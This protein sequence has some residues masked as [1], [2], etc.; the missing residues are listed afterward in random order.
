MSHVRI[1]IVDPYSSGALLADSLRTEHVDM[2]AIES[3]PNLPS[4]M[5]SRFDPNNFCE[6]VR[7]RGDLEKTLARISPFQPT[8]VIAGFESGVELAEWLSTKLGLPTNEARLS[9]ARRDKCLMAE[10]AAQSG[11]RIAKQFHSD[12][13][14]DLEAWTRQSLDW[15]VI[16]KPNRSVASD[17]VFQCRSID[18]VRRSAES[19]FGRPNVLGNENHRALVQEF[20]S[21]VEYAVDTVSCDGKHKLTAVWQYE[22]PQDNSRFVPYDA[23]RL[24]PY[25][26][27]RQSALKAY[28]FR[29]LDALG[30]RFGPAH[31][32]L[33]WVEDSPVLIE[34]GARMS[35]GVNAKLSSICGGI[36]QLDETISVLLNPDHF[37]Q[38]LS[39]TPHLQKFA[40]NVFLMP[41]QPGNLVRTRHQ[42]QLEN[43][44]TLHTMSIAT[45][46]GA[47]IE[48]VAG[49][50]TLVSED[51]HMI[52]RDIATIRRLQEDGF[53]D[54]EPELSA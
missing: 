49:L 40:A 43:L 54:T 11:L 52:D 20:L 42:E 28:A 25:A 8:H 29:L 41:H 21:G 30:I 4:A 45:Q 9:K 6:V 22:R 33:M 44:P 36:S 26:G 48:R 34:V 10:A 12:N 24:L 53:F 19:I 35:A 31:C 7:H 32:E 37:S 13:V 15:P 46:V 18:E 14:A 50:V 2:L 39:D 16:V 17:H 47:H 51:R 1:A 3:S 5:K 27:T 23:M 38:T